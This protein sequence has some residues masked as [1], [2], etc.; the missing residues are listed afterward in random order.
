MGDGSNRQARKPGRNDPCPCGSARKW[1]LCCGALSLRVTAAAAATPDGASPEHATRSCGSCTR[2][3]DGWLEGEVRGHRMHPGQR[4]HFVT[5]T[6]CS[7]YADRPQSPCRSFVCGWMQPGS[8]LPD[9]W[10]PDRIGVIVVDTHWR[11]APARI[12]VSAGNDPAEPVLD[13]LRADAQAQRT[14]FFYESAGERYG[15]GPADFQREM[16]QRVARGEKLW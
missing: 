15:Y 3:C 14:P 13:W 1:K 10:R 8:T 2:C 9:D 7:I 12:L 5:D 11:G 16:A 6:G 4:C